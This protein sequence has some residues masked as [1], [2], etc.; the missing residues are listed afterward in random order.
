MITSWPE[1]G[2]VVGAIGII[3]GAAMKVFSGNKE[4]DEA[5]LGALLKN[6]ADQTRILDKLTLL[7]EHRE[8][9]TEELHADTQEKLNEVTKNQRDIH[10]A[11]M[12]MGSRLFSA[13]Q[14]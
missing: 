13:R 6:Q 12:D 3:S 2:A 11:I 8:K 9:R 5:V 14:A 4:K 1:A 7:I 10:V